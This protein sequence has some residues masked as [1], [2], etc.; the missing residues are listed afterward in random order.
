[1]KDIV[2]VV[3]CGNQEKMLR[4]EIELLAKKHGWNF[5]IWQ[6]NISMLSFKKND[7]R[8]NIYITTMTVA[9][10][11]NHPKKGKTQMFRKNV[12]NKL[13]SN[14]FR[15]PRIHANTGYRKK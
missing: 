1:M 14:I 10:C 9:T 13:M 7:M 15:N 5:L 4:E 12:D 3:I 8:I 6:D 2:N 11:L